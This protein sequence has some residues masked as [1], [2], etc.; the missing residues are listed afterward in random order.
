MC[1]SKNYAILVNAVFARRAKK[2]AFG[3]CALNI[4]Y[5]P[6]SPE[7]ILHNHKRMIRAL[8]VSLISIIPK[9]LYGAKTSSV[10]LPGLK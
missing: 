5:P 10:G 2:T 9:D 1:R 6:W 3:L 7:F 4:L 8:I